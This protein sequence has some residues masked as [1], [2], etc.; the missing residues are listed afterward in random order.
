[1]MKSSREANE[2]VNFL[3]VT[4]KMTIPELPIRD[5]IIRSDAKCL[6]SEAP[7][8]LQAG[9]GPHEWK[10]GLHLDKFGLHCN[11]TISQDLKI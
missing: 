11:K 4:L 5:I 7:I 6:T 2:S 8:L 3:E 9:S 10:P 1:M